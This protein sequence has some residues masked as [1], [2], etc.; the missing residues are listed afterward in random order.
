MNT[1][2][3]VIKRSIICYL[4][5]EDKDDSSYYDF[6][7]NFYGF[8]FKESMDEGIDYDLI[9]TM[10]FLGTIFIRFYGFSISSVFFMVKLK[11]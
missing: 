10:S 7:T 1:L 2:Y 8:Y 6:Y 11:P 5:L 9:E 4:D 3:V